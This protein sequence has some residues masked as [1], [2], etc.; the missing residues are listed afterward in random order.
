MDMSKTWAS[1]L[2]AAALVAAAPAAGAATTH[3]EL[4]Q[5]DLKCLKCHSKGLKKALEDGERMSLRVEADHFAQ[6][7]HTVIGC[8][9]CHRDVGKSKHPSRE[10]IASAR[11]YSLEQNET[12]HQCHASKFTAYQGSIHASLVDS[13][14]PN[15]PVCSDCHSAHAV[16]PMAVYDPVSGEPC[17]S[18]HEPIYDAYALS[19]HGTARTGGNVLREAH[20]QAPICSDCHTAHDVT[21]VAASDHLK[22]TCLNCHEGATTA[23]EQWLPNAKM[24]MTSVSC[25]AC[26]APEAELRVDLQLY[27]NLQQLPVTQDGG[28]T[29][30]EEQ[31]AAADASGEG[32]DPVDLWKLVRRASRDGQSADVTLR[33]RMEVTTGVGAHR[34]APST[35]AVRSCESC[36]DGNS[37]AF[38][39]VTVSIT[40]GDGRK[41]RYEADRSVL[42]SVISVD[43]VRGFYAPGGTRIKLLDGLLVL[44]ILAGAAV[45]VGHITL[46]KILRRKASRSSK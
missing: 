25:A 45:P 35:E 30:I 24:H 3:E 20:I 19:V 4:S 46:G 42:S 27:D 5:P 13:G 6:S 11:A 12:C 8:T 7:V 31:L 32:L 41:Q 29:S 34:L 14:D 37:P 28:H 15:A 38:Q 17:K 10:P 36:H 1:L 23:H 33:G 18:C 22:T 9:G 40:R 21:A 16:Q 43:S 39:S 26:H 2:I 44:A